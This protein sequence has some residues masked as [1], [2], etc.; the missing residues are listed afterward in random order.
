V[1][2]KGFWDKFYT[3]PRYEWYFSYDVASHLLPDMSANTHP[4]VIHG[5]CGNT[6][7]ENVFPFRIGLCV[8]FDFAVNA[9]SDGLSALSNDLLVAD[10]MS[11]PFTANSVDIVI[12]KGLFDS[13]T[14]CE[15]TASRNAHTVLSEYSRVLVQSGFILI[16][17]IFGADGKDKDMLGLLCHESF[18]VECKC[19]FISPVEIPTQEFCYL[20]ILTKLPG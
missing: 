11:L 17:S 20:Y 5:G 19:M 7:L 1:S 8:E 3:S 2:S 10:A 9:F 15:K 14:S 4:V 6:L 12:E 13:V 16:F 18:S